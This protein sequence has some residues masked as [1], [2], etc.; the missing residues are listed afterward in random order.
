MAKT[1]DRGGEKGRREFAPGEPFFM[2]FA[3][4]PCSMFLVK[5]WRELRHKLGDAPDGVLAEADSCA[6]SLEA[7]FRARHSEKALMAAQYAF[8]DACRDVITAADAVVRA[9][10]TAQ[11]TPSKNSLRCPKCEFPEYVAGEACPMC[12]YVDVA[13][14]PPPPVDEEERIALTLKQRDRELRQEVFAVFDKRMDATPNKEYNLELVAQAGACGA[15][16]FILTNRLL[17]EEWR[18]AAREFALRLAA[19]AP[20]NG[21]DIYGWF[22]NGPTA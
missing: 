4:D 21:Q 2:L 14:A 12:K 15:W 8:V 3:D 13:K 20:K 6:K 18:S 10:Q 9:E 11:A 7:W 5:M 19:Q 22:K 17:P 1:N 16:F